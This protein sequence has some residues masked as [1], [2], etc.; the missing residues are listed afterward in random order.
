MIIFS[1]SVDYCTPDIILSGL[2]MRKIIEF[3]KFVILVKILLFKKLHYTSLSNTSTA[4]VLVLRLFVALLF[5][6]RY[7]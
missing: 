3:L 5:F 1:Q 4:F 6:I 7:Y 2:E